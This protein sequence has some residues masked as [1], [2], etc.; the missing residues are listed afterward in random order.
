M[1]TPHLVAAIVLSACGGE[2]VSQTRVPGPAGG[3]AVDD[4]GRGG[5]PVVFVHSVAGDSAHWDAQLKHLRP[6]RQAVALDLRGHGRS[7]AAGN[8]DYRIAAMADYIGAVV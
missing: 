7:E 1:R 2:T 4:G 8:G 5:L 6:R 3:M